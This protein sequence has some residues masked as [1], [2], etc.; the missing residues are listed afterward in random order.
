MLVT[1]YHLLSIAIFSAAE[2]L[3]M[4]G[5]SCDTWT[6]SDLVRTAQNCSRRDW[7]ARTRGSSRSLVSATCGSWAASR[8][9]RK[10]TLPCLPSPR[11]EKPSRNFRGWCNS[12][13]TTEECALVSRRLYS[14]P[15]RASPRF[16]RATWRPRRMPRRGAIVL[17]SRVVS[18][19]SLFI[20]T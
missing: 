17:W 5:V 15:S 14:R 11:T 20:L 13:T 6:I 3:E 19:I 1:T 9:L 16:F 7:A 10:S 18:T 2:A 8:G 4:Y 12:C